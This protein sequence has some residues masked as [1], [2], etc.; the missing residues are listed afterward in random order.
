MHT[1]TYMMAVNNSMWR[2]I[3]GL[4]KDEVTEVERTP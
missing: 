4:M 1:N 3:F 2:Y